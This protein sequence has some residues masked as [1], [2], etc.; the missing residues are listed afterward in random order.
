MRTTVLLGMVGALILASCAPGSSNGPATGD[1]STSPPVGEPI[2]IR[3]TVEIAA[4]AGSEPI[5]TGKVVDGS[6]LGGASFCVGGTIRD[7]HAN[8]D[9]AIEKLGLIDRTF[10]CSDGTVRIVFTPGEVQNGIQPGTWSVVSGTG[11]FQGLSGGGT[12]ETVYGP[13]EAS[14]TRETMTGTVTR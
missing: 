14:E 9:P 11:T 6:T 12:M 2:V 7:T 13:T 4:T 3:D 1:P 8:L 10:T 5:A